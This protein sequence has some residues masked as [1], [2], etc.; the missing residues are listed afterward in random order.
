MEGRYFWNRRGDDWINKAIASF[1]QA[2]KLDPNYALAYTGLADTYTILGDHGRWPPREAFLKAKTAAVRALEIDESLAEAHTSLALIK[3]RY[4]WDCPGAEREYKRAIELNPDYAL[5]YGWY[6]LLLCNLKRFDAVLYVGLKEYE[7][8][9]ECLEK[10]VEERDP[11]VSNLAVESR[12]DPL[13]SH[14]RFIAL[15]QRVGFTP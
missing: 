11:F 8:A 14:A 13:R 10:A 15:L 12:F 7:Q 2:I 3:F 9:L 6:S 1:E 4:D 5:V